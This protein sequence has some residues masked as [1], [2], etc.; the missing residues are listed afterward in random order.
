MKECAAGEGRSRG[1]LHTKRTR[2]RLSY[3]ARSLKLDILIVVNFMGPVSSNPVFG[4]PI[5][6]DTLWT[7]H[8]Y[9]KHSD[10]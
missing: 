3:H 7:A 5:R 1:R 4:F 2:Y 6:Q 10:K 9:F 8:L